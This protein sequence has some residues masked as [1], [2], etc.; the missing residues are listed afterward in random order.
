M[1]LDVVQDDQYASQRPFQPAHA[2]QLDM[3][4][5]SS[6]LQKIWFSLF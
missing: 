1:A 3:A 2:L 6:R 4:V 5:N